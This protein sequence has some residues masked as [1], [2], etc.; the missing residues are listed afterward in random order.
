MDSIVTQASLFF[1]QLL[2]SDR[3]AY[4]RLA[5]LI[6]DN[7]LKEA[8]WIEYKSG[9]DK[10]VAEH[11][12]KALSGFANSGGGIIIWGIQTKQKDN[13]DVPDALVLVDNPTALTGT[14]ENLKATV[15]E[16][17]V[18]GV[19][20]LTVTGDQGKGFVVAIVP[21]SNQKP[22]QAKHG[23]HSGRYFIRIGF[24]TLPAPHSLLRILFYPLTTPVI[25]LIL[26]AFSGTPTIGFTMQLQIKNIGRATIQ[27]PFVAIEAD[28]PIYFM[29]E[30]L[31]FSN[32]SGRDD[33]AR[34]VGKHSIH[35]DIVLPLGTML[36]R[37]NTV[38]TIQIFARDMKAS[39]WR[40]N[41]TSTAG[42]FEIN[43]VE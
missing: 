27:D 9:F 14:L 20:I 34:L 21:E 41:G 19:K 13:H 6:G 43:L 28:A 3:D 29:P 17:P 38:V 2:K 23:K 35:P 1:E 8:E 36:L 7:P 31:N 16:P 22:H 39:K 24:Q 26:K 30:E 25:Q 5:S 12:S 40:I 10:D 42:A 4:N 18:L 33:Q 37:A 15:V 11:W 32:S